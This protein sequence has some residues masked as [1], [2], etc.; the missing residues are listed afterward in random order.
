MKI[1]NSSYII[2]LIFWMQLVKQIVIGFIYVVLFA[3]C[4]VVQRGTIPWD[5]S[6]A[7]DGNNATVPVNFSRSERAIRNKLDQALGDWRG[8]R[9]ILGG[10]SKRGIDCSAFM[11]VVFKDYLGVNLPRTTREQMKVG[12]SIRRRNIRIGD[13][14]FFKTGRTTYHVGVMINGE[15]FLHASTSSGVT[16]SNIQNQY[17]VSTYLTTRR[18]L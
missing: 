3:S 17:W 1:D 6:T 16:I 11:Q 7:V 18:I 8:T 10:T 9:Y 14:V 5:K 15:Q 12:S 13:M 4:G 2:F